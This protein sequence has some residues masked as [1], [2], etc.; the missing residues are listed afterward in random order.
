M[1]RF[2]FLLRFMCEASLND[3]FPK[4][5]RPYPTAKVFCLFY[6][7][8]IYTYI[9]IFSVGLFNPMRFLHSMDAWKKAETEV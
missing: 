2:Y 4:F 3:P 1:L 7:S 6:Y 5:N 9:L 8:F